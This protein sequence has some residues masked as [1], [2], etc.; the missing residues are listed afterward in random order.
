M[1]TPA[2]GRR[3]RPPRWPW[4]VLGTAV[5][6][7]LLT[8]VA[9]QVGL[10]R[11][12]PVVLALAA[13]GVLVYTVLAVR[14]PRRPDGLA[15]RL[16]DLAGDADRYDPGR[17]GMWLAAGRWERRLSWVA[18]QRDRNQFAAVVQPRLVEL[19]DLR[20]RL[21]HGVTRAGDPAAARAILGDPLWTFMS[22]PVSG[23]PTP[24]ELAA[25]V[26]RIEAL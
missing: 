1:T 15:R 8:T 25:L 26:A 11:L 12:A 9:L 5:L 24:G 18:E 16:P 7:P 22:V 19:A 20:L 17:N 14:A 13:F 4:L 23:E 2:G 10:A 6:G 21:R 3:T